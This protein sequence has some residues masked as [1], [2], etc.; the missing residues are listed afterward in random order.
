MIYATLALVPPREATISAVIQSIASQVGIVS[1]VVCRRYE[2]FPQENV[3]EQ[4]LV[5]LQSIY[6]N[7]RII[8]ATDN[9]PASKLLGF[10]E[11]TTNIKEE[12]IVVVLD[13]DFIYPENTV[14]RLCSVPGLVTYNYWASDHDCYSSERHVVRPCVAGYLGYKFEG[15]HIVSLKKFILH[16]LNDIPESKMDDD[17][18]VTCFF[19]KENILPITFLAE[20]KIVFTP[21]LAHEMPCALW[22]QEN[23][24]TLRS[25]VCN[26]LAQLYLQKKT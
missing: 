9:G 7:L 6:H 16:A 19:R 24:A 20:R 11:H 22:L 2:R 26:K 15:K 12:D 13:D 5:Q 1:L 25:D 3:N 14:Q 4:T 18:I 8:W 10:M 17:A 23:V 21:T